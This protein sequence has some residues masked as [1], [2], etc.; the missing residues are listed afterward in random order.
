ML[1]AT[2]S[3][4]VQ[5]SLG[6]Q[7]QR[8]RQRPEPRGSLGRAL[9][10][11]EEEVRLSSSI[12][13]SIYPAPNGPWLTPFHLAGYIGVATITIIIIIIVVVVVVV[14]V[15]AAAV[16]PTSAPPGSASLI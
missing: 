1:E 13:L 2:V 14:V 9:E 10:K 15:A 12:Y 7:P 8:R 3:T 5:N 16:A 11:E 6:R 4:F